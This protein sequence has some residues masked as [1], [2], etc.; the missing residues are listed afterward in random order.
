KNSAKDESCIHPAS[1]ERRPR[2]LAAPLQARSEYAKRLRSRTQAL[3]R[4]HRRIRLWAEPDHLRPILVRAA[5]I[6]PARPKSSDLKSLAST[7]SATLAA[8]ASALRF[9]CRTG[10]PEVHICI[11]DQAHQ[12]RP[13]GDVLGHLSRVDLVQRVVGGVVQVEIARAV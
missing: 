8:C 11:G 10:G 1:A 12:G 2:W 7:S 9:L 3:K 4:P 6:E 13:G 5:G